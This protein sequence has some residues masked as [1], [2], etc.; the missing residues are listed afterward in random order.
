MNMAIQQTQTIIVPTEKG[1]TMTDREKLIEL[2]DGFSTPV[3]LNGEK[4]MDWNIPMPGLRKAI[5][6]HLLANDVTFTPAI[7]GPSEADPNIMELCFHNGERNMKEKIA[8][9]ML[10]RKKMFPCEA[11]VIDCI[12]NMLEGL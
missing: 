11:D 1:K 8:S 4:L 10:D 5:A 7:P 3:T 12:L 6:D 2:L 9:V